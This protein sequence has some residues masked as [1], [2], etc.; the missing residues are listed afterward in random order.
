MSGIAA[1]GLILLITASL[2][3]Y[4]TFGILFGYISFGLTGVGG[5]YIIRYMRGTHRKQL[6]KI[7]GLMNRIENEESLPSVIEL[8]CNP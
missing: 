3:V 4:Y 8:D 1:G 6:E 5:V 2:T 7:N